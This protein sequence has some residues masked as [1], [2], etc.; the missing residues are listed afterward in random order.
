MKK[1]IIKEKNENGLYIKTTIKE[2]TPEDGFVYQNKEHIAVSLQDTN[3]PP[4]SVW[5]RGHAKKVSYTTN[6]PR[7]TRPFVYTICGIFLVIGSIF[8]LLRVWFLGI[9]CIVTALL[10]L[11]N[12]KKDIDS[13]EE[14]L[15][16]QGHDMDS[17]E[18][19]EEVRKEF[20]ET[21]K[22]GFNEAFTKE[23]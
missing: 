12:S 19:K 17:K 9:I 23:N 6:D 4:R 14:D 21:I 2:Q 18:K 16:S 20:N 1:K 10:N 11:Y 22:N 13:I 3:Y 8:L 15:K 5:F 7:I